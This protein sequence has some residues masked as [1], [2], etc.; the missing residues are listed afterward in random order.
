MRVYG[1]GISVGFITDSDN[2]PDWYQAII[3]INAD[4]S[5][6]KPAL[7]KHYT[8]LSLTRWRQNKMAAIL[9][10]IFSNL[11]SW[12]KIISSWLKFHWNM[13]LSVYLT[14]DQKWFR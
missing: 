2:E 14:K 7:D 3:L 9:L 1:R 8:D 4:L 5:L 10:A 12:I 13:F 6:I 11:F